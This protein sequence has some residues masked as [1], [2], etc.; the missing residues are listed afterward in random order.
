MNEVV[1]LVLNET[2]VVNEDGDELGRLSVKLVINET[3]N[4]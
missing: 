3:G 4:E 2:K 1:T